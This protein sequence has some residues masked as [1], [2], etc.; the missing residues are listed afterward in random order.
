MCSNGPP[1]CLRGCCPGRG[2]ALSGTRQGPIQR[3]LRRGSEHGSPLSDDPVGL[4]FR[5]HLLHIW[6]FHQRGG[7]IQPRPTLPGTL[8][9]ILEADCLYLVFGDLCPHYFHYAG[10]SHQVPAQSTLLDDRR[11]MPHS[12]SNEVHYAQ[13]LQRID[14]VHSSIF[15]GVLQRR[16]GIFL[17]Q[18]VWAEIYTETLHLVLPEQNMGGIY[19][20]VLVWL[21]PWIFFGRNVPGK[22]LGSVF[23]I[24]FSCFFIRRFSVTHNCQFQAVEFAPWLSL[25]S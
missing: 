3:I 19:W 14:L 22:S 9:R 21:L 10:W 5:R 1:L 16:H 2:L 17:R 25:G 18:V 8:C 7:P 4:V 12:W 6:G 24:D 11:F 23:L 20:C 13:R 15:I